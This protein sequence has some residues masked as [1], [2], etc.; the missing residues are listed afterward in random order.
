LVVALQPA[1]TYFTPNV[2]IDAEEMNWVLTTIATAEASIDLAA[3]AVL[4]STWSAP[5][6]I[7]DVDSLLQNTAYSSQEWDPVNNQWLMPMSDAAAKVNIYFSYDGLD[8]NWRAM[9]ASIS[10]AFCSPVTTCCAKD[11][12][13]ATT[14]FL[15][16]CDQATNVAIYN[17]AGTLRFSSTHN[18]RDIQGLPFLTYIVFAT[19]G[20]DAAST[21]FVTSPDK[22]VTPT[23]NN[24]GATCGAVTR[25]LLRSNGTMLLAVPLDQTF[26]TPFTYTSTDGHTFTQRTSFSGHLLATDKIEGLDWGS[27]AGGPCWI[28]LVK[29]TGG[30]G[31]LL[32]SADGIFWFQV[33]VITALG[34]G[35]SLA[36]TSS[37]L[38]VALLQTTSPAQQQLA[39]S[40]D[41]INWYLATGGLV[42]TATKLGFVR[43]NGAQIIASNR[44]G[45]RA[46]PPSAPYGAPLV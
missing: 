31:K 3:K 35:I 39:W 23:T 1:G 13:D 44:Y 42:Q 20:T 38:W 34:K 41:T 30:D 37:G 36:G 18:Y 16:S 5:F 26:A 46:Q 27:D 8:E 32:R 10:T 45:V 43:S 22:M 12:N 21:N 2:P 33:A 25:W 24:V 28:M 15:G 40:A 29:T 6:F 11:P 4:G 7:V 17:Q 9:G 14:F 19:G